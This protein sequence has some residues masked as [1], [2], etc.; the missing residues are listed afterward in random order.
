MRDI[1]NLA[2]AFNEDLSAWDTSR[3]TDVRGMFNRA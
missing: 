3:V 2:T 1:F